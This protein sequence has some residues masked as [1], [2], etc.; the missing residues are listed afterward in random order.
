MPNAHCLC[1]DFIASHI[2]DPV[3]FSDVF[4]GRLLNS[5]DQI[6]LDEG[7]LLDLAYTKAVSKSTDAFTFFKVWQAGLKSRNNGKIL[8]APNCLNDDDYGLV[9]DSTRVAASTFD[10]KILA[11][12]NENY[13]PYIEQMSALRISLYN[14]Q[15]IMPQSIDNP[16]PKQLSFDVLTHDIGWILHRLARTKSK[17]NSEDDYNDHLRNMLLCKHYEVKDQTREGDSASRISAGELDVVIESNQYLFSII[18]AMKLNSLNVAYINEHYSKLLTNYNPLGV[19]NSHLITYFYGGNF[20]SWWDRYVAHISEIDLSTLGL[21]LTTKKVDTL[22]EN[23]PYASLKKLTQY[24][25]VD[26]NSFSTIHYA[27]RF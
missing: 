6:I 17:G 7:G 22:V 27:V 5:D 4:M 19:T 20:E 26:G 8:L 25:E 13:R 21:P 16:F 11:V 14:L 23:M 12:N 1:P 3:I 10:K 24:F 9:F 15:N 18:E 2:A